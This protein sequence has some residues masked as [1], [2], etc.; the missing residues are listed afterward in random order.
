MWNS[1]ISYKG[2]VVTTRNP[3]FQNTL[4]YD[5]DI[6]DLPNPLNANLGN[7]QTAATIRL[8]SPSENYIVQVVTATISIKEPY[9]QLIKSSSDVNAGSLIGGDELKYTLQ[10]TNNGNDSS[11]NTYLIDTIPVGTTYK[12]GSLQIGGISKTDAMG[13]DEAEYDAVNNRVIFRVGNGAN[14]STGGRVLSSGT[15]TLNFSV[16][17]PNICLVRSCNSTISNQATIYYTGAT[18]GENFTSLSGGLVSGC[19]VANPTPD[20]VTGTCRSVRDTILTNICPATSILL[21]TSSFIGYRFYTGM[22]FGTGTVYNPATPITFT[23]VIYAFYDGP[24][25]CDDTVNI[26][27]FIMAC[28]D[29]DDDNDGLPDYLE[30]NNAVALQDANGNGTPNWNDPAYPGYVDNNSDG[31]NDNFDPSADADNDGIPNFYDTNFSGYTDSNGDG[32]NDNMD[33]DLDGI[34]NHL[35]LDSDNDGI[36]DT[37]ES[38]G[39]DANGDGRIDNYTDTDNDGFSQNVDAN[40]TGVGGSNTGLGALDTDGDGL[41]NYLDS[42]SDNDGI[43]DVIEAFGTDTNNDG[44]EDGYTD[45]DA[46]GYADIVDADVGNDNVAENAGSSLMR[47]SADGNADGRLDSWPYKNMDGDS[48]SNPYDVDSDGDGIIDT[49]EAGFADT[50]FNGQIDGALNSKGWN[51]AVAAGGSLTLPNTD[52]IGRANVYDIDSDEDGVP[53]NVE[54]LS[55]SGYLLPAGS[56]TDND[57]LDNTYDN[58]V[59]FSG[60]GIP[61]NDQDGDGIP[62]YR[63]SDTDNDGLID[64]I[65]GNDLNLNGLQ[66]DNVTLTGTDTDGDGLDNRFDNDNS[67]VEATSSR[68]GNGGSTSGDPTPGSI[69]TVQRTP[70]AFGCP[71]ERD[72]RCIFYVLNCEIITFKATLQ[73]DNVQLNWTALCQQEVEK[74]V[75]ERSTDL[76]GF[77][78]AATVAGKPVINAIESYAAADNIS[79]LTGDMIY[80]R[81]RIHLRSGKMSYS[82]II[83]VRRSAKEVTDVHILPNPVKDQLQVVLVNTTPL[84][85][86]DIYVIDASGKTVQKYGERIVA[87]SNTFI[88]NQASSLPE[89]I[90]YL[91]VNIGE[92]ILKKKFSVLK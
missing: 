21:P 91:R 76:A 52:G 56:D 90:Y 72:W 46:D 17:V 86:A 68:M 32:V 10:Y 58:I 50:D 88:Y 38:F 41:A 22:P 13:D 18:S 25:V 39:V 81:L 16:Y 45:T 59:G 11:L 3:A 63:D 9:M 53:D 44:K 29:I 34:P 87:G 82:N 43:P 30:L 27:C 89:G 19:F 80:Y 12:T 48:K 55:T 14:G 47:T 42:D 26:S 24:G 37:V 83:A 5:A 84:R 62:D 20:L 15:G 74:F 73:S 28:P 75:V 61:P 85:Y 66:D 2:S 1:T 36:P 70:V 49:K 65:E 78:E 23:R 67:S 64:R 60:R 33:K 57:G 4:G 54:G 8:S 35:D 6:I 7:N 31:F 77:T 92:I 40:N 51:A 79:S 71:S 69:T